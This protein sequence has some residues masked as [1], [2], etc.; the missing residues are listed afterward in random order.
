MRKYVNDLL[1]QQIP[2]SYKVQISVKHN[3]LVHKIF[4]LQH[5]STLLSHHQAFQKQ[6]Q[7]IKICSAFWDLKNKF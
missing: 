1:P 2:H 4:L 6:I 5:V 7:Y 3:N